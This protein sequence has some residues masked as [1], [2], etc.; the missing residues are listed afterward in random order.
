[1]FMSYNSESF[2]PYTSESKYKHG[3]SHHNNYYKRHK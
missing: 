3:H 2:M 1:M